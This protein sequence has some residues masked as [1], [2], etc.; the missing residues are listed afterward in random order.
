MGMSMN[1][2]L[3]DGIGAKVFLENLAS[4]SFNEDKP[5]SS[6]PCNNRR[7]LAARSPPQVSFPHPEIL[8]L[9]LPLGEGSSPPV[10][11]CNREELECT[12]FKFSLNNI[13]ELKKKSKTTTISTLTAVSAV[14]WRCKAFS[15][16]K[17]PEKTD[18]SSLL[19][20]VDVRAR[21]DPPLPPSYSGNAIL[22]VRV[23]AT[24]EELE[25]ELFSTVAGKIGEAAKVVTDEYVRSA[26]D[27]SE[28]HRGVPHGDYMVSSWLG[29]GFDHIVYPWG[30][31][32]YCCP[33][34]NHRKDICWVFRDGIDGGVAAM[35]AL[36]AEEMER[37]ENHF[38][39]MFI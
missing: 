32:F 18:V 8:D 34:V 38:R 28:F 35:V 5:L 1:H 2:I 10:F 12:I 30:K 37:F 4:Q 22:A 24:V 20:V 7:L 23:S 19:G 3:F 21:V 9:N 11:D 14:I 31:P 25:N 27:W 36:P 26:L 33:V 16:E 29:L 13:A 6:I 15:G 39:S 17:Q